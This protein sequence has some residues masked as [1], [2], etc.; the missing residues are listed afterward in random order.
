MRTKILFALAVLTGGLMGA[1]MT[2]AEGD[3]RARFFVQPG[4]LIVMGGKDF[5]DTPGVSIASGV[6]FA[7]HHSLELEVILFDRDS[8]VRSNRMDLR[9]YIGLLTYKYAFR[10]RHGISVFAGGSLGN[11]R[12]E[13]PVW[14]VSRPDGNID[15]A[16]AYGP[17]G[18]VS[19]SLNR[20]I[21]FEVG[22]KLIG[23]GKTRFTTSGGISMVQGAVRFQF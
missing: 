20:C 21:H 2:R 3:D 17:S 9:Y 15:S 8:V 5:K 12:E 13:V 1:S 6:A 18:G 22:G 16:F 19:Y 11:V 4:V 7:K 23:K 14:G 10:F